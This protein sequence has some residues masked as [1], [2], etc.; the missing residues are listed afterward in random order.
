MYF[1]VNAKL[2]KDSEYVM[3]KIIQNSK[4]VFNN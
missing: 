2:Y 4:G 1:Y 3:F